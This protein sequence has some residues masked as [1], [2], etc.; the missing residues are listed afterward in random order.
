M[1]DVW[2]SVGAGALEPPQAASVRSKAQL[3][4]SV[5]IRFMDITFQ[6]GVFAAVPQP[7]RIT[8]GAGRKEKNCGFHYFPAP[9]PYSSSRDMKR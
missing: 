5:K 4:R 1:V 8:N 3:R 7:Y 2:E 6:S 9:F